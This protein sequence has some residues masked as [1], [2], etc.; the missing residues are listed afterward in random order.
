MNKNKIKGCLIAAAMVISGLCY[1]CTRF[2]TE[3]GKEDVKAEQ[4]FVSGEQETDAAAET[5]VSEAVAETFAEAETLADAAVTEAPTEPVVYYYVHV[6]GEVNQPGVYQ[7]E[8]GSRIFQAIEAAGGFTGQAA[9]AYVNQAQEIADGMRIAIPSIE[10]AAGQTLA[11]IEGLGEHS[12]S[13]GT[14][15][16]TSVKVNINTADK[17][18]L[19]T[20]RGIGEARAED[21]IRYREEQGGFETIE[22]IM[23]I[24][25]IKDAAF[26]KIKDDITV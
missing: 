16:E 1:G 20:L 3:N 5:A 17:E 11:A 13:A 4:G 26:Q 7:L 24:S 23:N 6:C 18:Q 14:G 8:A 2:Y 21:I 22:E 10:E 19:M 9:E 25:G 15:S 12:G